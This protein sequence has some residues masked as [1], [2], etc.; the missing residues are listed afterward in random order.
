MQTSIV[1]TTLLLIL[2]GFLPSY[3]SVAQTTNTAAAWAPQRMRY[4]RFGW[5]VR[6]TT[7]KVIPHAELW[8]AGPIPGASGHRIVQFDASYP[9]EWVTDRL[10]NRIAQFTFTNIPP[11]GLILV[12]VDCV[13][14]IGTSSVPVET[15]CGLYKQPDA[16]ANYN[17]PLFK[18][19]APVFPPVTSTTGVFEIY[20]WVRTFL[21]PA[22]FDPVD[23]GAV[24][25]LQT[26]S[27]DCTEYAALFVAL[28]RSSG[29]PARLVGGYRLYRDAL[30]EPMAYHNWAEVAIDGRWILVDP[31]EG[32]FD[33]DYENYFAFR[34]LGESDTPLGSANR[35]A[36]IGEGVKVEY[37]R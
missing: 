30:L 4:T 29:I 18:S 36:V 34:V 25:A 27:G 8:A 6:N 16:L 20:N 1:K 28:C 12:Y 26:R 32:I 5:Q 9:F 24:Y 2:L 21:Q 31:S 23:R 14:E 37:V 13:W 10:G 17:D 7:D 19:L 22:S 11:Y 15:D 3:R 33:S 35:F